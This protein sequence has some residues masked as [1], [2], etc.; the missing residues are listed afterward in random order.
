MREQRWLAVQAARLGAPP[1]RLG[2]SHRTPRREGAEETAHETLHK[3]VDASADEMSDKKAGASAPTEAVNRFSDK[4]ARA[5]DTAIDEAAMQGEDADIRRD[6][7]GTISCGDLRALYE[8]YAIDFEMFDYEIH[9]Y[10]TLCYN[11]EM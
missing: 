10:D 4:T 11:K 8:V 9:P 1:I 5:D 2:H 7:Y 6:Y 3:A